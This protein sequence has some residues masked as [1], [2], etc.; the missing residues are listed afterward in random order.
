MLC[1]VCV[2]LQAQ[3]NDAQ[4]VPVYE[5]A[6]DKKLL[7]RVAVLLPLHSTLLS[8]PARAVHAG[9]LAAHQVEGLH[10]Q[11]TT[12]ATGATQATLL[13]AFAQAESAHDV[14]I[15]PLSRQDV[16]TIAR[17][18]NIRKP[19][20]ALAQPFGVG[21]MDV[22]SANLLMIGLPIEDEAQQV[23]MWMEQE[24]IEGR[25]MV[26]STASLWQQRAAKAFVAQAKRMGRQ[27]D[28]FVLGEQGAGLASRDVAQ[29]VREIERQRPQAMFV[30]LNVAQASIV[31]AYAGADMPMYGTS[32]L[33][34]FMPDKAVFRRFEALDG[35]RLLDMPWQLQTSR[36][37]EVRYPHPEG[38]WGGASY[39]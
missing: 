33:N 5:E 32:H 30:A 36:A 13:A 19:T 27:V 37:L 15:G 9:I 11:L 38:Y 24:R 31:R 26:V 6:R 4:S 16:A 17:H 7:V 2:P 34:I 21:G 39:C 22:P 12:I 10:V 3:T 1:G 8:T 20:I 23:A 25:V 14:I 35:V 29:L 28:A 18:G